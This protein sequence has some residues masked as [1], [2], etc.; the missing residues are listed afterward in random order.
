MNVAEAHSG[1]DFNGYLKIETVCTNMMIG[2]RPISFHGLMTRVATGSKFG[3][4]FF[5]CVCGS[6]EVYGMAW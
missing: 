4:I 5:L 3:M 1:S 2:Y 6:R